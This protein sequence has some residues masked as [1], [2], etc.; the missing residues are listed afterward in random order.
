[1]Y[2]AILDFRGGKMF[3]CLIINMEVSPESNH[4]QFRIDFLYFTVWYSD[5]KMR[6]A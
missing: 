1:M 6:W 3:N 4:M 5:L 2:F